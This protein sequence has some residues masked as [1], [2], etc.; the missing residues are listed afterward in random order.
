MQLV[1]AVREERAA[2]GRRREAIHDSLRRFE[3]DAN[4]PPL[5]DLCEEL[6]RARTLAERSVKAPQDAEPKRVA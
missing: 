4:I 3:R 6:A 5:E 1:D 2:A